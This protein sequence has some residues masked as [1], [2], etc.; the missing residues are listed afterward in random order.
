MRRTTL[1][2]ALFG[3]VAAAGCG[4][5]SKPAPTGQNKGVQ[6]NQY[7]LEVIGDEQ[8]IV[9]GVTYM[10]PLGG[11]ITAAGTTLNCGISAGV[12]NTICKVTVPYGTKLTLTANPDKSAPLPVDQYQFVMFAGAATGNLFSYEVTLSSDKFVAVRFAKDASAL[13]A[14]PNF[15]NGTI[16]VDEYMRWGQG[17]SGALTCNSVS[18]HGAQGQGAGYA[19]ACTSCHHHTTTP[20]LPPDFTHT[21]PLTPQQHATIWVTNSSA[22]GTCHGGS[23]LSGGTANVACTTCHALPHAVG[24][25][26]APAH[27]VAGNGDL[28]TCNVC[29]V[30]TV[31]TV[32]PSCTSCHSMTHPVPYGAAH[33]P[34]ASADTSAC[35]GCHGTA[36]AGGV[37][38]P[39][40]NNCH[41]MP[42]VGMNGVPTDG[43]YP[44]ASHGPAVFAANAGCTDCHGANYLGI[45]GATAP[46]CAACHNPPAPASTGLKLAVVSASL[47]PNA[48]TTAGTATV[49]FTVKDDQNNPVDIK[50]AKTTKSGSS[51][52]PVVPI[53]LQAI[54]GTIR[55]AIARIDTAADGQTLPYAVLTPN[56][57]SPSTVTMPKVGVAYTP[58]AGSLV[59]NAVGDYTFTTGLLANVKTTDTAKTHALWFQATR[60]V[61]STASD[62]KGFTAVNYEYNF[63]GTAG[64]KREVVTSAACAKCHDGFKVG[65]LNAGGTD[66]AAFH[67]G[68]RIAGPFC[69]VCHNPGRTSN[70]AADAMVFVHRIHGAEQLGLPSNLWFH[71]IGVTYPMAI[72]NCAECHGGAAQGNQYKTRPTRAACGSCHYAVDFTTGANHP[73]PGGVRTDDSQCAICHI[74][75]DLDAQHLPVVA[76]NPNN[77]LDGGTDTRQNAGALPAVGALPSG[78]ARMAWVIGSVGLDASRHPTISFK[79]TKDG[80][81]VV[82]NASPATAPTTAA[83]VVQLMTGFVGGP[84]A[85]F[86]WAEPEQGITAPADFNKSASANILA[87]LNLEVAGATLA[88]PDASGFYTITLGGSTVPA[89][90]VMLTGGVGYSYDLPTVANYTAG[91]IKNQPLTQIDLTAYP[92]DNTKGSG[93]L[94]TAVPNVK[95]TATG[96][97]DRRAIVSNAK[98]NACHGQ[99]GVEPNFHVGQRNDGES[100]SWCHNPARTSSQWS[101]NASTFVHAIHGAGKRTVG[102]N[103]HA[104]ACPTGTTFTAWTAAD[105]A[106]D[107]TK[108]V[109]NG[110]CKDNVSGLAVTPSPWYPGVEYP[111]HSC[112]QCHVDGGFDYS[113]NAAAV[114]SILWPT[115]TTG[116]PAAS[117]STSPY[118]VLGTAYGSAGAGTNLMSSPISSV[119]FSCH[120]SATATAHM[121]AGGGNIYVARSAVGGATLT[122]TETCLDCHG[123]GKLLP[124]ADVHK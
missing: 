4:V 40:C 60:Q 43:D 19:P 47:D 22:C 109:N 73:S 21:V 17:A 33:Q 86:V 57:G 7:S 78:A 92:Y 74:P 79:F 68:A 26:T 102:Y 24:A 55:M 103:W 104:G 65:E 99:L 87:V 96:F 120:D 27:N 111:G 16:H 114:P 85:Y 5:Q 44:A 69:D 83:G 46:S 122:N 28:T 107:P 25:Y 1:A 62:P 54:D 112:T 97:T 34:V 67:S 98:C 30:G 8:R 95:M 49:R 31:A 123:V 3:A 124:I 15:S 80:A 115:V 48:T 6:N 58:T 70:P 52:P 93:G 88:G 11:T 56:S 105:V 45:A 63:G 64:T 116:T 119:C 91:V 81:D 9:G 41:G 77:S 10:L 53:S 76:K 42:H 51:G 117:I 61:G 110:W 106:A 37:T 23:S 20:P 2:L 29:H 36:L 100:C 13:G 101:T 39:A 75:A 89:T 72:S 94:V 113:L 32:A 108:S 18:C 14:H 71:S 84:S 12:P 38:A 50:T 121:Q 59:Q 82:F 35:T 118:V 66:W 90:A